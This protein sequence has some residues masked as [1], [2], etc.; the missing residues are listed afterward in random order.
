[1]R[2]LR[3][4]MAILLL[5][6]YTL[7]SW[8][9]ASKAQAT[10]NALALRQF[11]NNTAALDGLHALHQSQMIGWTVVVVV[12]GALILPELIKWGRAA[13]SALADA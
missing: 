7:H 12:V 6:G 13:K 5:A 2:T 9:G 8:N 10:A 1:M 11:E 3:W 4:V